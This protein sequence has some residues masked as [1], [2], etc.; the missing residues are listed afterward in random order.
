M[1]Q[2]YWD[3]SPAPGNPRNSEGAFLNTRDGGLL[4][5][6][7]GFSGESARDYTA[8]DIYCVR[9]R[10]G[11]RSFSERALIVKAADAGAMNVMSVSLL[12]MRDGAAA[13]FYLVRRSWTDMRPY[14][15]LS[16]DDGKTWGNA[17][18]CAPR[19]GYFVMNNDRVIRLT[20]GRILMPIA[21][22]LNAV[23]PDGTPLFAPAQGV[24]FYSDDDGK[25]WRES[26]GA[27]TLAGI[28]TEAGLQE[29]G[30]VELKGGLL[31]AWA[32]TD[33]GRQYEFYS[34]DGGHTW[35]T[36]VPAPFTS[37]L[38]PLSL[39]HLGDGRLFAVWNPVPEYQTRGSDPRTGGRTPLVYALSCDEG[40][41]WSAPETVEGDNE[42]GYCYTAIHETEDA[43]LLAY[44]AGH[45]ERDRGCL[46][47]L[48]IRRVE[49]PLG[50]GKAASGHMM[51]IGF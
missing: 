49:K 15:R 45:A 7:T 51:G 16:Y 37:P 34:R 13:M 44:C 41:T 43:V 26:R 8:A 38:S 31:Y 10:D 25:T 6:Y 17:V 40:L 30:A 36:P 5:C 39:K 23:S 29:P 1:R 21:E 9:S 22:H 33:L 12:R 50:G 20:S 14:M 18:C 24:F 3:I 4:F 35:S 27:V 48:R 47:R 2:A 19:S 28:R 42:S 32:R 46:N 11:G